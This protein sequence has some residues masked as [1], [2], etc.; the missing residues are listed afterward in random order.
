[1][2]PTDI[3][4]LKL[5]LRSDIGAYQD[6][7]ATV[8][9]TANNDPVAVWQDYSGN[10]N[11]AIQTTAGNRPLLKTSF[12]SRRGIAVR[13]ISSDF[14]AL[15]SPISWTQ[16]VIYAFL[17]PSPGVTILAGDANSLA[18]RFNAKSEVV[19]T[20]AASILAGSL[21]PSSLLPA[22]YRMKYV[23]GVT[24]LRT[25]ELT[26]ATVS[27]SVTFGDALRYIGCALGNAQFSTKDIYHLLVFDQDVSAVHENL[28][29]QYMADWNLHPHLIV[30]DGNSMTAVGEGGTAADS[31]PTKMATL[32]GNSNWQVINEGVS[33]Q[34]TTDMTADAATQIDIRCN[35][36]RPH[37]VVAFWEIGNALKGGASAA[38]A[39]ADAQT[40]CAARKAAGFSVAVLTVPPR[41]NW[42]PSSQGEIDDCNASLRASFPVPTNHPGIFLPRLA[43]FGNVL[44]DVAARSELSN[45]ANGSYFADGTHLTS[46]G[47]DLI[48][49]DVKAG[50]EIM[51]ANQL[52]PCVG[53]AAA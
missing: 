38:Q 25:W 37:N 15:T 3:P 6:D 52:R 42:S 33:G 9:A 32:F 51:F 17:G 53:R 36:R 28:I 30:C 34:T 19:K 13:G 1:M 2:T 43:T 21:T 18:W 27:G 5:W 12:D 20:S 29:I 8:P 22:V 16:G 44:I 14:L 39:L 50:I 47:Y 35:S 23:S 11:H 24:S 40:Y 26:D 49:T 4:G 48:A 45:P 31:W 7:A 46:A 41:T 10:N